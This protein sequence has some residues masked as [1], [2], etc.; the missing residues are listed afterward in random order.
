MAVRTV[1]DTL[2]AV[3]ILCAGAFVGAALFLEYF[4]RPVLLPS[5]PTRKVS[6]HVRRRRLKNKP[7][8]TRLCQTR[9]NHAQG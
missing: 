9:Y 7:S 6:L 5:S 1:L 3:L 4:R 2:M 8:E